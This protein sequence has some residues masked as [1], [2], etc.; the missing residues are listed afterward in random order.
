MPK[1]GA[2]QRIPVSN[3][4]MV[5]L[6][7]WLL[8]E[9]FV[10]AQLQLEEAIYGRW[11]IVGGFGQKLDDVVVARARQLLTVLSRVLCE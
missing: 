2:E 4:A 11:V 3:V 10:L 1:T 8:T 9:G 6:P 5:F 7:F